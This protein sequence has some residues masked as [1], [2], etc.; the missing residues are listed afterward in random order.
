MLTCM[1]PAL[2]YLP[3]EKLS[4]PEL[5]SARL[6]GHVVELGEGF[7]PSDTVEGPSARARGIAPL[8]RRGT[9]VMGP[10]AAWIHGAGDA[11][12]VRHHFQRAVR[13]RL[14]VAFDRRIVFHDIVLPESSQVTIGSLIVADAARTLCDLARMSPV[15]PE[16]TRWARA[17]AAVHPDA[18]AL[19]RALLHATGRVPGKAHGLALLAELTRAAEMRSMKR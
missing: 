14:R 1:H 17:L 8:V 13:R 15:Y 2:F 5:C 12:P 7:M 9:A 16:F 4:L 11:P 10:S 18:C 6:D 19:A 3:G